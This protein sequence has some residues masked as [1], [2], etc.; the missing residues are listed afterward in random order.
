MDDPIR[1]AIRAMPTTSEDLKECRDACT[2][3]QA[4]RTAFQQAEA[5]MI[6]AGQRLKTDQRRIINVKPD[7]ARFAGNAENA[8]LSLCTNVNFHES[9]DR[10]WKE[11]LP[12]HFRDHF[13]GN[14]VVPDSEMRNVIVLVVAMMIALLIPTIILRKD[15]RALTI[16]S[17]GAVMLATA[18]AGLAFLRRESNH[19]ISRS[20]FMWGMDR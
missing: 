2:D 10:E 4:K 16:G 3:F 15:T 14:S 11:S 17:M 8:R 19:A 9:L 7:F 5:E 6:K 20:D 12:A 13:E 18:V 1:G